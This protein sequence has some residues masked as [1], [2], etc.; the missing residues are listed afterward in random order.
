MLIGAVV[1]A[2]LLLAGA[3]SCAR[4]LVQRRK[5]IK[6]KAKADEEAAAAQLNSNP[7]S[8]IKKIG[9][10]SIKLNAEPLIHR[11]R[12][13]LLPPPP[14]FRCFFTVVCST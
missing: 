1:V 14:Q 13:F 5:L 11:G 10:E 7:L 12:A 3:G 4:H 9:Q 8:A 6:A 2:A